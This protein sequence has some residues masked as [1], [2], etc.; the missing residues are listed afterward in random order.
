M[1][2]D[3]VD[4][5]GALPLLQFTL[6]E[7][8]ERREDGV[9]TLVGYRRIGGVSGALARRAEQLFEA[10]NDGARDACRQVF[11]RLVTLGEGSEDTRRRVRRSELQPLAD[12]RTLDGVLDAFGRHRLLSF[13]RDPATRE[14][15]VEIAHEALLGAWIAT[16]RMDRR[17]PDD[18]RTQRRLAAAASEWESAEGTRAT[19]SAGLGSTRSTRMGRHDD[20]RALGGRGGYLRRASRTE[21]KD[22]RG[23]SGTGEPRGALERRSVK[24]LRALVALFAAAVLAAGLSDGRR[25]RTKRDRAEHESR[26]AVARELAAACG[27]EPPATTSIGACCWPI[28]GRRDD[29]SHDGTVLPEAQE[30]LGSAVL[31]DRLLLTIPGEAVVRFSPDG[32]Q[33]LTPGV[34]DST[35]NVYDASTGDLLLTIHGPG[36]DFYSH[37]NYSP[38]GRFISTSSRSDASTEV[39]NA[40]TGAEVAR[41]T[42]PSG[43]PVCCWAE[44]SPDGSVIASQTF[45][46]DR[47]VE[48]WNIETG[49]RV[50]VLRPGGSL[51]FTPDGTG[52]WVGSCVVTWKTPRGDP[53][54]CLDTSDVDRLEGRQPIHLRRVIEPQRIASGDGP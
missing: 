21:R 27:G 23:G 31:A 38:D 3:V 53:K 17:S 54:R 30:A 45:D 6:T 18:I 8:A 19:C 43:Q 12:A 28:D 49:E 4:R 7:L 2:A 52:L 34:E 46:D 29:R 41:L 25:Q 39:W 37:V 9:L 10:M 47:P 48:L 33:L 42:V 16:E 14:P 20:A 36:T 40:T 5:P 51:A 44:F 50:N 13:D 15:T 24:R 22:R 11:L 1:I 32:S 26:V 35:A